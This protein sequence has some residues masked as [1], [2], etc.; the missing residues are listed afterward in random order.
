MPL[1]IKFNFL[2]YSPPL[3]T[4]LVMPNI[5]FTMIY[6]VVNLTCRKSLKLLKTITVNPNLQ[7]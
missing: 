1:L 7:P 6:F 2:Y 3:L 5:I 4:I